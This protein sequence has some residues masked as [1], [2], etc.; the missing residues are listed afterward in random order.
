MPVKHQITIG[1]ACVHYLPFLK[2]NENA[3]EAADVS[4]STGAVSIVVKKP[5]DRTPYLSGIFV[6]VR[7]IR[8][9]P[10]VPAHKRADIPDPSGSYYGSHRGRCSPRDSDW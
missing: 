1:I 4:I 6:V 8:L 5:A 10:I 3:P 2:L 9:L 7:W